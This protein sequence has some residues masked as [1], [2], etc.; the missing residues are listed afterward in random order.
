M[1]NKL[2][3]SIFIFLV[4]ILGLSAQND[5][6][7]YYKGQK[8]YLTLDKALLNI[9]ADE[10]IRKS[11]ITTLNV[12]DFTF[13]DD[14]SNVKTQKTAKL[15]F[16]NIPTDLEFIQKINSLKENPNIS[17]VSFYYKR[18]NASSI[19]TSNL[20]AIVSIQSQ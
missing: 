5:H 1:K 7:Y 11:S 18:N 12:K 10:N 6:Y 19:G 13:E 8:V 20:M 17:N 3:L 2:R 14:N 9:S 4:S 15:E 16:Q